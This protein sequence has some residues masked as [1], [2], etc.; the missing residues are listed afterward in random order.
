MPVGGVAAEPAAEVVEDSASCHL[1]KGG[2]YQIE[3]G[4]LDVVAFS[5]RPPLQGPLIQQ[6]AQGAGHGKLGRLAEAALCGVRLFQQLLARIAQQVFIGH[7]TGFGGGRFQFG[8]HLGH[9]LG[10]P[11]EVFSFVFEY[12]PDA[13]QQVDE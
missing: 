7:R 1:G 4:P 11:F 5:G 12:L 9:A 2:N 3:G 6:V 13:Q 8:Q 10:L